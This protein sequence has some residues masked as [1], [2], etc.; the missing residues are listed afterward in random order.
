MG[1]WDQYIS[2]WLRKE[3]EKP[4]MLCCPM[5]KSLCSRQ[6]SYLHRKKNERMADAV[7]QCGA[8]RSRSAGRGSDVPSDMSEAES[9]RVNVC[10]CV[11]GLACAI[12]IAGR[13]LGDRHVCRLV[14]CGLRSDERAAAF[15]ND[16]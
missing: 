14:H 1:T 16:A 7:F 10:R 8:L 2:E 9:T 13:S 4:S 5:R 15:Q 6:R 3:E 11:Q 12:A